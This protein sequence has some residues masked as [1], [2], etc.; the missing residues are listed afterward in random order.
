MASVL[1]IEDDIDQANLIGKY[2]KAESYSVHFGD[3]GSQ[4][5]SLFE[6]LKPDLML[7][8]IN[9]PGMDGLAALKRI[10][11][12]SERGGHDGKILMISS[13][14]S[15]DDIAEALDFGAVDYIVKPIDPLQLIGK[16]RKII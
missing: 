13:R 2:L 8:D 14:D 4:A 6:S 16:I 5:V 1:I 3:R 7:L 10:Y 12:Q 11:S 15:I 9:L